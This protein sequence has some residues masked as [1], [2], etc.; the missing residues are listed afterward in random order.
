MFNC[1]L[2]LV[3]STLCSRLFMGGGSI[4]ENNNQVYDAIRKATGKDWNPDRTRFDN[5]IEWSRTKCPKIAVATSNGP[6]YEYGKDVFENDGPKGQL[7][8]IKLF[9]KHGFA[10]KHITVHIDNYQVH[11]FD[12]PQGRENMK[13]LREAD[14]VFFNGGDQSRTFTALIQ[15]NSTATPLLRVLQERVNSNKLIVYGT[16]AGSMTNSNVNYGEGTSYGYLFFNGNLNKVTPG[17]PNGLRDDRDGT[18]DVFRF[19]E[20]GGYMNGFG[21]TDYFIDTHC[22]S[23]GRQIRMMVALQTVG[24]NHGACVDDDT[25]FFLDDGVGSV[26][27]TNGVTIVNVKGT[28]NESGRKYRTS[29]VRMSFLTEGDTISK[30]LQ[31]QSPKNP[32][33]K[34]YD[35]VGF[36]SNDILLKN[37]IAQSLTHLVDTTSRDNI[38]KTLTLSFFPPNAHVYT[39]RFYKDRLTKGYVSGSKITSVNV[40]VEVY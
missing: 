31:I 29:G 9:Q 37:Q 18:G 17:R 22:S 3:P 24:S 34:P 1:L 21:F 10:S 2:L 11:A 36:D 16:S 6:S 30:D 13:T 14:I 32:I 15:P 5:C 40:L 20:N 35:T 19:T 12:T 8:Y 23:R 39:V 38:G 28:R 33:T 25:A 26:H 4:S 7:S 27:G